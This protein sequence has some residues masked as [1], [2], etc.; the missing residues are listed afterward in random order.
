M[1]LYVS[2]HPHYIYM[3]DKNYTSKSTKTTYN[4]EWWEYL[5]FE[6]ISHIS[7]RTNIYLESLLFFRNNTPSVHERCDYVTGAVKLAQI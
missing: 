6:R 4:L 1:C 3:H 2:R 7:T 5:H